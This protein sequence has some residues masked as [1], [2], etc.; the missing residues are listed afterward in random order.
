VGAGTP[1][2][3]RQG[4][5]TRR[6]LKDGTS[7]AMRG[8][9]VQHGQWRGSGR[10]EIWGCGFV[11][12]SRCMSGAGGAVSRRQSSQSKEAPAHFTATRILTGPFTAAADDRSCDTS[13]RM[14]SCS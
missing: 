11:V 7:Q 13:L 9:I 2:Q 8:G 14:S 3:L 5:T 10:A 12:R 6:Q 4:R 1:K